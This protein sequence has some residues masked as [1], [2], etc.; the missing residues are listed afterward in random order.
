MAAQEVLG[1][2]LAAFKLRR[3]GGGSE[4]AVARGAEAI[5]YA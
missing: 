5:H 4:D 3:G 1:V 2:G